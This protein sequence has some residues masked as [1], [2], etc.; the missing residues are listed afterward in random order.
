[1]DLILF[2][3]FKRKISVFRGFNDLILRFQKRIFK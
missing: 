3:V 2:C 1:M